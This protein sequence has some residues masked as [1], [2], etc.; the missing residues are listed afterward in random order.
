MA[1]PAHQRIN[2]RGTLSAAGIADEGFA[3]GWA[4]QDDDA[5]QLN[6]GGVQAAIQGY[7]SDPDS[8]I[9]SAAVC[10]GFDVVDVVPGK[11]TIAASHNFTPGIAGNGQYSS[12]DS[13]PTIL[14]AAVTLEGDGRVGK[15]GRGRF[16]PPN[17]AMPWQYDVLVPALALPPVVAFLAAMVAAN[18]APAVASSNGTL[19]NVH[20][21]SMDSRVD[22]QRRRMYSVKP[23]RVTVSIPEI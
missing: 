7:F 9:G 21:V 17:Y 3:F 13:I 15:F 20:N 10:T 23:S 19:Y 11:S 14:C 16:Y 22:T 2:I 12:F 4:L 1:V 6:V 18:A 8:G 5:G